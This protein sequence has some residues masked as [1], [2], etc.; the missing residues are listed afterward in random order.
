MNLDKL[1]LGQI[2][3]IQKM[4]QCRNENKIANG[5]YRIVILQ[6]GWVAVGKLTQTGTQCLLENAQI[7]RVWGTTKGLG[8]LAE[9]G[10]TSS[11]K[12]D[13]AGN[14]RFHELSIVATLDTKESLWK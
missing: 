11:T 12:L 1:T 4:M 5:E 10:K 2:K 9:G 6:R 13:Y 14:L 7:I 3:E 8:E